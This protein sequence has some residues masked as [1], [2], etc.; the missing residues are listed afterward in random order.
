[1]ASDS[2]AKSDDAGSILNHS[3]GTNRS[4]RN[5]LGTQNFKS[6]LSILL[7]N[8]SN[9]APL[10]CN[11]ERIEA[12]LTAYRSLFRQVAIH[13]QH[14]ASKAL[15]VRWRGLLGGGRLR[16]EIPALRHRKTRLAAPGRGPPD[17]REN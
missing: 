6:E 3:S 8:K 17:G 14:G 13:T 15:S 16:F 11:I 10:I 4:L 9:E 2:T 1:M 12:S 5:S 7:G